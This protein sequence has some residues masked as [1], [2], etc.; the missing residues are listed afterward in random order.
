MIDDVRDEAE[1]HNV[2][3][4]AGKALDDAK[5]NGKEGVKALRGRK[6]GAKKA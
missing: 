1:K 5:K 3:E 6:K 4:R 2:T